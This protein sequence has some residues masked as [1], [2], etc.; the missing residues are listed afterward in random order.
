[1]NLKG[2]A[3]SAASIASLTLNRYSHLIPFDG[4]AASEKMASLL[5]HEEKA[6]LY[7]HSKKTAVAIA[8]V[9]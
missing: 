2:G 7:G 8:S 1:M 6:T 4:R 3:I 9:A 5:L